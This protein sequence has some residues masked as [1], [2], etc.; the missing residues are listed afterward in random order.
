[1]DRVFIILCISIMSLQFI[2]PWQ[3]SVIASKKQYYMKF[4]FNAYNSNGDGIPNLLKSTVDSCPLI[5]P[6]HELL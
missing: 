4:L 6:K 3:N 1:M 5:V 2:F